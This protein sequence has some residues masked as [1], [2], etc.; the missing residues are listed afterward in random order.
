MNKLYKDY[1]NQK[2]QLI[3]ALVEKDYLEIYQASILKNEFVLKLGEPRYE[4]HKLEMAIARNKLKLDM[5]ETSTRFQIQIDTEYIDRQLEKEFEKHDVMLKSMKRE[6][7][8]V[9]N[10]AENEEIDFETLRVLKELYLSIARYIHPELTPESDKNKKRTWKAAK[11]AFEKRDIT[12]LKR[13][14]KK[15]M[16]EFSG[17]EINDGSEELEKEIESLKAK[18]DTVL[19]EIENIKKQFP[20]NEE[21]MLEDETAVSKFRNDMDK[22]IKVAKEVL[23]KLEKQ[24][25][26]KLPAPGGYLN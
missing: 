17:A 19:S 12:K 24:I 26:E 4:L 14:H 2:N 23:D 21:K 15:V 18:T 25:L 22:D 1:E 3:D 16:G 8:N 5:M 11:A 9:H 7:D 20:F 10:L 6:I 13:L